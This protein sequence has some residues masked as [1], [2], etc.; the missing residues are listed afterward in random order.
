MRVRTSGSDRVVVFILQGR[1]DAGEVRRE[2]QEI[3]YVEKCPGQAS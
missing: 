1:A 3:G 2:V